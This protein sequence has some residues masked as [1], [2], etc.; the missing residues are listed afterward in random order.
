VW[1]FLHLNEKMVFERCVVSNTNHGTEEAGMLRW[2][3]A[4]L[5][6]LHDEEQSQ[7]SES[8]GEQELRQ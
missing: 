1:I 5:T 4:T 6:N 3:E 2:R 8:D 7:S